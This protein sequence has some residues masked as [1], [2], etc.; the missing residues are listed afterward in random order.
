MPLRTSASGLRLQP[1]AALKVTC[2]LCFDGA[3]SVTPAPF[4]CLYYDAEIVVSPMDAS[5][6]LIAALERIATVLRSLQW[7]AAGAEG[8]Y[9]I[10]LQVLQLCASRRGTG[11]NPTALAAELNVTVPSMSDT[12]RAL[13][14]KGYISRQQH[15]SDRRGVV[16]ELTEHGYQVLDRLRNWDSV[17]RSALQTIPEANREIT[18]E[19]CL[20]LLRELYRAG[21]IS[22]P[23]MCL[24]CR[25]LTYDRQN[26]RT[27]YH[28]Q[29]L[30]IDLVPL[31]LRLECPEHQAAP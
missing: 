28:C 31:E 18:Y 30:E 6:R 26:Y 22:M 11:L 25:W 23:R 29:L 9:P 16:I 3:G 20:A 4:V 15:P 17:L 19:C 21:V 13:E 12:L 2:F 8:L 14:R 10:Q 7:S 1:V 24:T 27:P 5:D